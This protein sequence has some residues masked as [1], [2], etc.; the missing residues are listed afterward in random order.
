[1]KLGVYRAGRTDPRL[2]RAAALLEWLEAQPEGQAEF[3][4]ILR[5]GPSQTRL[6]ASAEEALGILL[7]H[8]RISEVSSRPRLIRVIQ[9]L[10][11]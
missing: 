11:P 10:A 7:E 1:M 6:K 9:G 4:E 5:L 2:L 8:G 3:R